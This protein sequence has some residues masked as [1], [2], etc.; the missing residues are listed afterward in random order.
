MRVELDA[1]E[2]WALLSMLVAQV[3]EQATLSDKDRA[4]IRKWRSEGMKPASEPLRELMAKINADL[5]RA[6]RSKERSQI[7]KPDWR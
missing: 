7:R 5:D 2:T 3:A 4:A 6:S 1:D